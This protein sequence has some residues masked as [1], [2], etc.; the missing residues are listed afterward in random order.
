MNEID[1]DALV[2]AR[3]AQA[4]LK[5]TESRVRSWVCSG[6]LKP[7]KR[8]IGR[9]LPSLYRFGDV[10]EC[11]RLFQATRTM[12][13]PAGYLHCW[14]AAERLKTNISVVRRLARAGKIACIEIPRTRTGKVRFISIAAID[15]RLANPDL[16]PLARDLAEGEKRNPLI[17]SDNDVC[18]RA[19]SELLESKGLVIRIDPRTRKPVARVRRSA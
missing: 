16:A 7:K 9:R 4:Q 3:F 8:N 2:T 12:D 13:P 19:R 18:L 11:S 6:H 10:L 14:A 5:L 17:A 15:E 1:P